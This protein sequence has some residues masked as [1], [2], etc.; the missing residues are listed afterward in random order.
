MEFLS[1]SSVIINCTIYAFNLAIMEA[2]IEA[3]V[4]YID[5]GGLFHMTKKQ[6][7]L[8]QRF[9][10]AGLLA[11]LGLGSTPGTTNV[12]AAWAASRLNQVKSVSILSGTREERVFGPFSFPYSLDTILDEFTK[13]APIFQNG[14]MALI[15]P[16]SFPEDIVFPPPVGKMT[17]YAT[18]HSEQATLPEFLAGKGLEYLAFKFA[19]PEQALTA[20][21]A[22]VDLGL[23]S[24]E[25]RVFLRERV[26]SVNRSSGIGQAI[27]KNTHNSIYS[28]TTNSSEWEDL[29]VV[30][31]GEENGTPA[32]YTL[33]LLVSPDDPYNGLSP[34]AWNTAVPSCIAAKWLLEGGIKA[35]GALPPESIIEPERF[36]QEM[37]SYN[38]RVHCNKEFYLHI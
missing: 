38:L 32:T 26:Y 11:I 15:P 35:T 2:A 28:G 27:V 19:L 6:L 30:V 9:K 36:F 20:V 8:H 4:H 13:D 33:D 21:R 14:K 24:E 7:P 25:G 23:A 1:G 34:G 22:L 37:A 3:R 31:K 5:L 12:M 17:V 16:M 18:I 10:D 29:R